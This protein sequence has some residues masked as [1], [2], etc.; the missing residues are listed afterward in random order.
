MFKVLLNG[1]IY[2]SEIYVSSEIK[3]KIEEFNLIGFELT[4][5][6]DSDK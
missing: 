5:M 6:W 1:R 2:D 3:E 4:E